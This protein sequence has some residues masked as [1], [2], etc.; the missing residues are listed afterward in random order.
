MKCY[1]HR[2]RTRRHRLPRSALKQLKIKKFVKG[3]RWEV[4]AICLDDFEDGAKLRILPCDH[5][6]FSFC[7]SLNPM[8][9]FFI[10]YHMKCIDPWLLNN[11]RQCPVCKRY[12]FPN[13][14]NSDE[15]ES[16]T[17]TATERTPLLQPSEDEP[18]ATLS[19]NRQIGK[20]LFFV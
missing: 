5:G 16:N 6:L 4:C 17:Q 19:R 14:D 7:L 12:V 20:V 13:Q 18:T 9:F 2:R 8:S 3:D 11:R 15:E 1:L 10:A